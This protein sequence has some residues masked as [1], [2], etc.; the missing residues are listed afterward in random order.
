MN[1]F[2]EDKNVFL[3]LKRF[4]QSL[5]DIN[6]NVTKLSD[7]EAFIDSA[8]LVNIHSV[9]SKFDEFTKLAKESVTNINRV[10]EIAENTSSQF[11]NVNVQKKSDV[12]QYLIV[13]DSEVEKLTRLS[14]WTIEKLKSKISIFNEQKGGNKIELERINE[15]IA[16]L[17]SLIDNLLLLINNLAVTSQK[18]YDKISLAVLKISNIENKKSEKLYFSKN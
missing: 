6:Q 18:V 7:L 15:I 11:S 5:K 12:N 10:K 8:S 17:V 2:S 16:Y 3:D 1:K 9:S 4:A 14:L 13:V